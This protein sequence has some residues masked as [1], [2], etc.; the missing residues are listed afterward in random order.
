MRKLKLQIQI[1]IDGFIA[2][3]NGEM[4]WVTFN[5]SDDLKKYVAE[6]T[7]PVDT[8]LIGRKLAEGFIPYWTDAFKKP[9]PE[10][11]AQK[12]VETSKI[13]FSKTLSHSQWDNTIIN[14]GDLVTEVNALKHSDGNDLIVYGGS[15]FVS[16][17]IKENL[18]DE[19]HLFINPVSIGNGLAIFNK[20]SVNQHYH[21]IQSQKFDCGIVVNTYKKV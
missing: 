4:D 14:N 15:S 8:I 6:L 17:L 5:W 9:V 2:G 18:I 3:P 7:E 21:L 20:L 12:F 13:I 19:L 16:S 11:G 10:E 1:S